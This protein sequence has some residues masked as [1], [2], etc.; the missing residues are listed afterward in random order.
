MLSLVALVLAPGLAQD[1]VLQVPFAYSQDDLGNQEAAMTYF[2]TRYYNNENRWSLGQKDLADAVAMARLA[3]QEQSL[4]LGAA[5]VLYLYAWFTRAGDIMRDNIVLSAQLFE[6]SI[7]YA[8]C[9]R[10]LPTEY[11]LQLGCDIR[12]GQPAILYAWLQETEPSGSA[13]TSIYRER[14]TQ[15]LEYLKTVPRFADAGKTWTSP[16]DMNFNQLRYPDIP[17]K[18]I[19]N[20]S[21][22]PLAVFLEEN[23]GTFRSELEG[24]INAVDVEDGYEAIRRAD[25][26]VE[27]LST[28]GGWDAIRIVRYGNWNE[29]F[30]SF[31]PKTCALLKT[32]KELVN[33][34]YVNTNY[35]KLFPGAH[36]KPHFGNAPRLTAHLAVIAPEPLRSGIS[37]GPAQSLWIEGKSMVIDDTYP[38]SVSH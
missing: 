8:G 21:K 38:H 1:A 20:A 23:Y 37:V 13:V 32:R 36:L 29:A 10:D 18:P 25:V 14:A 19:W 17:A 9:S 12:F 16:W 30:C 27:S 24:I 11:W 4:A 33:C 35:Y 5:Q 2:E 22:V 15:L 7:N 3:F 28:P 34:P 31:A 26:S 6:I